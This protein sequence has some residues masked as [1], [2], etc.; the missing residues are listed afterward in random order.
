MYAP[1]HLE[2]FLYPEQISAGSLSPTIVT[3]SGD[4]TEATVTGLLPFTNYDCYVTA[5]TSVGE[6]P[7][8]DTK[9]QRTV[10]NGEFELNN[11]SYV[12]ISVSHIHVF[13]V[14]VHIFGENM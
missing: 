1:N 3:T 10:K 2:G 12:A 6:G 13:R 4:I 11:N 7:P 5:N 9:T 14:F 8:S